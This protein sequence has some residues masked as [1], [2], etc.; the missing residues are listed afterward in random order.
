[1]MS[2]NSTQ[3]CWK[4]NDYSRPRYC[5]SAEYTIVETGC[6]SENEFETMN[7]SGKAYFMDGNSTHKRLLPN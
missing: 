4:E 3:R 7:L 6:A 2:A 5:M 1:M